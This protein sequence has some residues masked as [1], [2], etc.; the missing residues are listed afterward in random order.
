MKDLTAG[1]AGLSGRALSFLTALVA[2][3]AGSTASAQGPAINLGQGIEL[4]MENFANS[5][6][7]VTKLVMNALVDSET[8]GPFVL[9]LEQQ[10][11][12]LTTGT[13]YAE[14]VVVS[15]E[16]RDR[17]RR[18]REC[19]TALVPA[20]SIRTNQPVDVVVAFVNDATDE[21]TEIYRG[22]FPVLGFVDW[23][24]MDGNR[25]HHVEQRAL[26]LDSMMGAAVVRQDVSDILEFSYVTTARERDS[27]AD[28]QLR[29]RVDGGEWR[30]YG[31]SGG[32]EGTAQ[33]ARN[34]AWVN[35]DVHDGGPETLVTRFV[36]FNVRM[37]I[38]VAGRGR[39]PE[40]GQSMDGA[41]TCEFR[42][43]GAGTR[44]VRREIRFDVR[45]GFIQPHALEAQIRP[46]T[47]TVLAAI[48]FNRA[49]LPVVIDPALV[50]ASLFGIRL[51]GATAPVVDGLPARAAQPAFTAPRGG[52]SRGGRRR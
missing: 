44:V 51:S 8:E 25:P 47:G 41:W 37:P 22:T 30:A 52:S 35:G 28:S 29:C 11:H 3:G 18:F 36:H 45:D 34:R 48:G 16:M 43:G 17:E 15:G 49:L 21:R 46:G 6:E 24:G 39:T 38:A 31:V 19:A 23:T 20:A 1:R 50:R 32:S 14:A 13:C 9:T 12:V 42:T 33:S 26:R 7:G 10:G 5:G 40:A 4:R 2:L 27:L